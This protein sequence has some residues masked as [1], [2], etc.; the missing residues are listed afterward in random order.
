MG[1]AL[2]D[3]RPPRATAPAP[4]SAPRRR[5]R[6]KRAR[7]FQ[8][9]NIPSPVALNELHDEL[10]LTVTKNIVPPSARRFRL[11]LFHV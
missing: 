8:R 10:T 4:A 2:E 1:V 9:P 6:G 5:R 11:T 3:A 7:P